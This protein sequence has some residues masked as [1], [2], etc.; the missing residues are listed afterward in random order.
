[1]IYIHKILPTVFSPLGLIILLLLVSLLGASRKWAA[2]ALA[3]LIACATP[4]TSDWL[5]QS[6]ERGSELKDA[7]QAP[8]AEAVVVLSGMLRPVARGDEFAYEWTEAADRIFAGIKLIE[9]GASELLILTRG[10]QPWSHGQP[11]GDYLAGVARGRGIAAEVIRLTP[12]VENT[13]QEAR[14]VSQM[15][16]KDAHILLVT[17]AFHMPR[18]RDVFEAEGLRVTPWP[19]DFRTTLRD[20]TPMDFIPSAGALS[21]TSSAIREY[22]GRLY[23]AVRHRI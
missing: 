16:P 14:A 22:I 23:Y 6:L 20:W 3:V 5:W 13:A 11:E 10:Q 19:V 21:G 15:L 17:S 1:M 12:K 2:A 8:K 4:V 18:A 9:A 7:G